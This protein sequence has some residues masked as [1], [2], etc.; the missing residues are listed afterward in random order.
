MHTLTDKELVSDLLLSHKLLA[1]QCS[2]TESQTDDPALLRDL[3]QIGSD[4]QQIRLQIYLAMNQRGWYN[5]QLIDQSQI[6]QARSKFQATAA[7]F[8]NTS[9][10]AGQQS[11][12]GQNFQTAARPYQTGASTQVP[13]PQEV[14][15][16]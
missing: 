10:A 11:A 8:R 16:R 2:D 3:S 15:V 6:D 7:Q 12:Y 14:Q 4:E 5:P 1:H 13:N 9:Y